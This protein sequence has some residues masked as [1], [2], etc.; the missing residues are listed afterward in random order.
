MVVEDDPDILE[1][2]ELA[3]KSRGFQT[4]GAS[5]GADAVDICRTRQGQI[6]A[7]VA[8]LSIPGDQSRFTDTVAAEYPNI[9]IVY[10]T[11]IPRHIALSTGMV[12]AN[13]PYL[14]KPVDADLLASVLRGQLLGTG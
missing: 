9:K 12:Q 2:T 3:L 14:Q 6:D 11:G 10:A 8:D 1:V 4:L 13:A 7:I 5:A